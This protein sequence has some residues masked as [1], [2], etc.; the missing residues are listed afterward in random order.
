MKTVRLSSERGHANHGWLDS[1]HSFS[2][3]DYFDPLQMGFSVLRVINEDRIEGGTGFGMHAHRDM[4]II[5]YMVDGALEHADSMGNKGVIHAGEVQTMTAGTGVRHS[6]FNHLPNAQARLLQIWILPNREGHK[7][8]YAQKSFADAIAKNELVLLVSGDGAKGSLP[9]NQDLKLYG[10]RLKK[11]Q[12]MDLPLV[13]S[14][15]G[16]VQIVEGH[17]A[18]GE[19]KLMGGDGLALKE[20]NILA[21]EAKE[22]TE[23]LF[24]DLP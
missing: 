12:K 20:E 21:V 14:R 23:L 15:T 11:G 4:E 16:W 18:V 19:L 10:V 5:T 22:D 13:S 24:F 6:E 17:L 2:F 1:F 8:S 9:V 3:A 7:P